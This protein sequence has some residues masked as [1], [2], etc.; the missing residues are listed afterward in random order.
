MKTCVRIYKH[1]HTHT[2]NKQTLALQKAS[3]VNMCMK[4]SHTDRFARY[5]GRFAVDGKVSKPGFCCCLTRDFLEEIILWWFLLLAVADARLTHIYISVHM[6]WYMI[7]R[8]FIKYHN[9][10]IIFLHILIQKSSDPSK[11]LTVHAHYPQ[12]TL[13][14]CA[15]LCAHTRI[16]WKWLSLYDG[17]RDEISEDPEGFAKNKKVLE[18]IIF[19][20]DIMIYI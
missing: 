2:Y 17:L 12:T 4:Y 9:Q 10:V 18:I 8:N 19:N 16:H 6:I 3:N 7:H 15:F 1:T 14:I 5:C 20:N 11:T 13:Y